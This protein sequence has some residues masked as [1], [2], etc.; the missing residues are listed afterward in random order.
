MGISDAAGGVCGAF[1]GKRGPWLD[2]PSS[3][4][5]AVKGSDWRLR[6]ILSRHQLP[7]RRQGTATLPPASFLCCPQPARG[8]RSPTFWTTSDV[9][10]FRLINIRTAAGSEQGLSYPSWLYPIRTSS[11]GFVKEHETRKVCPSQ[12]WQS[13]LLSPLVLWQGTH[14]E[15]CTSTEAVFIRCPVP[16]QIFLMFCP[17]DRAGH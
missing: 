11:W 9:V 8:T 6:V 4:S 10:V 15:I 14:T 1:Q 13:P 2:I 17:S 5:A 7:P 16:I 3:S 12:R